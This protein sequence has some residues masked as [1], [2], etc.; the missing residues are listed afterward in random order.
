MKRVLEACLAVV[1]AVGVGAVMVYATPANCPTTEQIVSG[2]VTLTSCVDDYNEVQPP[3]LEFTDPEPL[4]TA[5]LITFENAGMIGFGDPVEGGWGSQCPEESVPR[6]SGMLCGS[7]TVPCLGGS[8]TYAM[9]IISTGSVLSLGDTGSVVVGNYHSSEILE[10]DPSGFTGVY[11]GATSSSTGNTRAWMRAAVVPVQLPGEGEGEGE[12]EQ[13]ITAFE[14]LD[15]GNI[16]RGSVSVVGDPDP[17]NDTNPATVQMVNMSGTDP[18]IKAGITVTPGGSVEIQLRASVAQ[19]TLN[20]R[21]RRQAAASSG[22]RGLG[23]VPPATAAMPPAPLGLDV[24]FV[25]RKAVEFL[26]GLQSVTP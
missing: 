24:R 26:Q 16:V 13:P 4:G 11:C 2:S 20:V 15:N 10:P 8:S 22:L 18:I 7:T 21:G 17:N 3:S 6:W 1:V 23:Q 19:Q 14:V 12:G 9:S 25:E 5:G